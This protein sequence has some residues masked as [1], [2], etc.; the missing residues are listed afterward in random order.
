VAT[1]HVR[2]VPEVLYEA[3]RLRA[4]R[5]GRSISG[6]AIAL[7]EEALV[8]DTARRARPHPT[9]RTSTPPGER[10]TERAR[11]TLPA[12]ADQARA[13]RHGSIEPE[14]ILLGLL[15]ERRVRL[16]L[17]S[18]HVDPG[19]LRSRVVEAVGEGDEQ[20]DDPHFGPR[21]K[22]VLEL[23]LRE[24]LAAGHDHIGT[25]HILVGIAREEGSPAARAL[26]E[27]GGDADALRSASLLPPWPRIG[28]PAPETS[29][30]VVTLTGSPEAWTEQLNQ[31][32]AEWE[33]FAVVGEG[34]E[35]R[36][37]FRRVA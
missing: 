31:G 32:R 30:R 12:A 28:K 4:E 20:V 8:L 27:L 22:L 5:V 17:E 36:A 9:R 3:L 18:V 19:E 26:T 23:A 13:L 15:G 29:Y 35:P 25:E 37:I 14:H 7:L 6:E 34:K 33:L 2:N 24:A 21:A 1:L 11:R 16:T 10:F